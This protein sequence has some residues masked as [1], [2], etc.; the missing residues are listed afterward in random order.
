[1]EQQRRTPKIA[2]GAVQTSWPSVL[3]YFSTEG[4]AGGRVSEG[5]SMAGV[6]FG[7]HFLAEMSGRTGE[8]ADPSDTV[9]LGHGGWGMGSILWVERIQRCC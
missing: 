6:F 4:L 9:L 3:S 2:K 5:R 8:R 1:M 7:N